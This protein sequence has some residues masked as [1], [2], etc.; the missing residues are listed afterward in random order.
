MAEPTSPDSGALNQSP[1]TDS[2]PDTNVTP[3]SSKATPGAGN[4]AKD[5]PSLTPG[6]RPLPG[7]ELVTR[8][9]R[10]G[11]GEVWRANGPGGVPVALKF[12]RLGEDTGRLEQR[13]LEFMKGVRNPHLVG[14]SG[15]W[16]QEDLLILAMELG[17]GTL[18]DKLKE[19]KSKALEGIPVDELR[20]FMRDA[21]VGI[22]YLNSLG[23]QHRDVK[24]QNLLVM[25]GGVKVADFG[26]AKLLEHTLSSNSGSMTPAYAAPE[27]F[28]GQTSSQSDQYSLAVTYCHLRGGRLPFVG[29]PAQVMMGHLMEQPDLT[30]LPDS[31]WAVVGRALAKKPPERF[32]N[33]REFVAALSAVLEGGGD[34]KP[35]P[36]PGRKRTLVRITAVLAVCA[37]LALGVGIVFKLSTPA[38]MIVIEDVP[39]DAEIQVD[40]DSVKLSRSGAT[41]T[42]SGVAD[43]QHEIRAVQNGVI[44]RTPDLG[45]NVP[46]APGAAPKEPPKIANGSGTPASFAGSRAGQERDDNGLKMKLCWCPAGSFKMGSPPNEPN[47]EKDE[48]Q[49][50]VTLTRGFWLG[51]YAVTQAEYEKIMG[52]NP[53]TFAA[54]GFR[55]AKVEG[56]NTARFPVEQVSWKQATEFCAKLTAQ[57]HQAGRLPADWEYRL[58]TEAQ[59]EY[60]CRAGTTTPTAFGDQ[61]SSRQANFDGSK[62]PYGGA[63]KGRNLERPTEVDSGDYQSNAWGLHQMHGNVVEWCHDGYQEKLPG[64]TDPLGA[65]DLNAAA[66]GGRWDHAGWSC[67]SATRDKYTPDT[68]RDHLGFRLAAV[69]SFAGIQAGQV[70]DDNGLKMKLCWCP[71][72]SFKMGSPPTEN[73]RD[74]EEAQADVT[75]TRGFWL[76]KYAVTQAEYE[77]IMGSNP[78]YFA[79]TGQGKTKVEGTNTGRFPVEQVTWEQATEF[80]VKLTAQEHQAGRLLADWEYRLPTEAQ[81]EYACRAGTTTATTFGDRLSSGQANFN[82]LEPYNG[83]DKARNLERTTEVDSG[84]YQSNAWGLHQMHGNT[85]EWCR[86]WFYPRLGSGPDPEETGVVAKNYRVIRGGGWSSSGGHCRSAFRGRIPPGDR[87]A[88]VGFRVAAVQVR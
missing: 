7:Y 46:K 11:F 72:G 26:L 88:N 81:R 13:S 77:K 86:D 32:A 73:D 28:S 8:L 19:A 9:G 68:R 75:L 58:P 24:P 38:G 39:T 55:K 23:I 80:C 52:Y 84:E 36:K 27:F 82:G 62:F 66:R 71:A 54:S 22:D 4:A 83:A 65:W 16:L 2:I 29:N 37:L 79:S 34:V 35:T 30:M 21:A 48:D 53:S 5:P 18:S 78:S 44:D 60:A 17:D 25:G 87:S 40:G 76:G 43:G 49:V 74:D 15:A 41:V 70:R 10:G 56:M 33:C 3:G 50:D 67:R 12:I 20:E 59:R 57:E 45:A 31:E 42:V 47:H 64:G 51:K 6:S 1:A 61:M 63:D 69:P 85:F 14:I